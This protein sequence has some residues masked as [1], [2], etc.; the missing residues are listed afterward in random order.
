MLSPL[1]FT[2]VVDV[3]TENTIEGL[4]NEILYADDLV[5]M[6]KSMENLRDNF[7]KWRE[8]LESKRLKVNFKKTKVMVGGSKEQIIKYKVDHCAK[9]SKM[10]MAISVLRAK[11]GKCVDDRCAKM[12]RVI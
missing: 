1:L 3:I 7:L 8:A 4:M 5:V 2:I 10:V 12:K 11:C 9:C 6:S